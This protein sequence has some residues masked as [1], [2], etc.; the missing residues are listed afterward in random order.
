MVIGEADILWLISHIGDITAFQVITST[1]SLRIDSVVASLLA[2][3]L[4]QLNPDMS[5]KLWNIV[6]T[7]KYKLHIQVQ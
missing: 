4:Y 7:E 1:I 3:T 5:H 6:S 2:E